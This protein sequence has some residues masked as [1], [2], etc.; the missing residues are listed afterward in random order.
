MVLTS[1]QSS[2]V[3]IIVIKTTLIII[4]ELLDIVTSFFGRASVFEVVKFGQLM[5]QSISLSR[6]IVHSLY[7]I[8]QSIDL[9]I[10]IFNDKNILRA[11]TE[12]KIYKK[13]SSN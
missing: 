3:R 11:V 9:F 5:K 8:N 12:S 13:V 1:T 4:V 6:Q 10:C 2:T 7:Y